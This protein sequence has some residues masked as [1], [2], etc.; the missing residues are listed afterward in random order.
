MEVHGLRAARAVQRALHRLR[1]IRL[2]PVVQRARDRRGGG[3]GGSRELAQASDAAGTSISSQLARFV[4]L[5]KSRGPVHVTP[6][7]DDHAG[8]GGEDG[9]EHGG[10]EEEREVPRLKRRKMCE[11][12]EVPALTIGQISAALM[13]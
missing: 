9:G 13:A 7:T 12:D 10:G 1:R 5:H 8:E 3:G 2:A 4:G 11:N 6:P